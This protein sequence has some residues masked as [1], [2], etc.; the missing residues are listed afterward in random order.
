MGNKIEGLEYA[1][2]R[3]HPIHEP[4]YE[5]PDD[6][7][8]YVIPQELQDWCRSNL[9][10][11]N[12]H[13][14]Y[15]SD[16]RAS[17]ESLKWIIDCTDAQLA[18]IFSPYRV[19]PKPECFEPPCMLWARSLGRH[20]YYFGLLDYS[21]YNSDAM[22]NIIND[23]DWKHIIPFKPIIGLQADYTVNPKYGRKK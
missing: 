5:I 10:V 21:D 23:I 12:P 3:L 9:I 16:P 19:T 11:I 22:Y 20:N 14:Y 6:Q 7:Q 17:Y 1:A 2:S 15:I 18:K 8:T 13:Y 4:T